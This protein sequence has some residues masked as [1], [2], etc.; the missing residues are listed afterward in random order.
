MALLKAQ[1][2]FVA[3]TMSADD[4]FELGMKYSTGRDVELDMINAHKW[5]N[6]AAHK[7]NALAKLRRDELASEMSR[8]EIAAAQRAAREFAT[9]H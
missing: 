3:S 4:F 5:L 2:A 6:I 8:E 7:G 1:E 9:R